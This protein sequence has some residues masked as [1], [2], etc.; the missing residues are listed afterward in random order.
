MSFIRLHIT[1]E[2][3]TEENFIKNVLCPHLGRFNISADVRLV[4]TSRN[5]RSARE[6]RG[7]FRRGAAFQTVKKD[8]QTWIREDRHSNVRFSTMFDLYAF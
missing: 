4:L 5:K 1:A 7:G 3:R 6:H 8:I 2:G